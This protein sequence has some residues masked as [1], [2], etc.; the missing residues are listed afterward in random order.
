V[1]VR[2]SCGC[3]GAI[4]KDFL[5]AESLATKDRVAGFAVAVFS[6]LSV[7]SQSP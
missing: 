7:D 3:V 1:A 5:I 6:Y 2:W 4:P